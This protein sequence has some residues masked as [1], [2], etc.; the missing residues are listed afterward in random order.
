M[1]TSFESW[2]EWVDLTPDERVEK[3]AERVRL[4]ETRVDT[5]MQRERREENDG[6]ELD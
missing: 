2:D 6:S 4:L 3:L 1:S 5:L